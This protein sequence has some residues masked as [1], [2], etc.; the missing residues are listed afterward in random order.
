MDVI[1]QLTPREHVLQRPDTYVGSVQPEKQ[2][3]Y[4]Y[5]PVQAKM[6]AKEITVV[7]ALYKIVDEI[8]VNAAD[9]TQ[10]ETPTTRIDVSLDPQSG[11]ISVWNDGNVIPVRKHRSIDQW[12]PEL[13]FGSLLTSDNYDDSKLRTTGGRN[14]VGA[15]CTNIL[16]SCFRVEVV[17]LAANQKFSQVWTGNMAESPNG[18]QVTAPLK[19]DRQGVLV[20]FTP[21]YRYFNVDGLDADTLGLLRR[22][23]HDIAGTTGVTMKLDGRRFRFKAFGDYVKLFHPQA[24]IVLQSQQG[25]W[26]VVV[27][28]KP[29]N[30]I[31][32]ALQFVNNVHTSAGGTHV[33]SIQTLVT[34]AVADKLKKTAKT[35]AVPSRL[36]EDHY[37]VLVSCLVD[38]PTFGSQG[39]DTL[40]LPASQ[41]GSQWELD[42]KLLHR[43]QKSSL[44]ASVRATLEQKLEKTLS[45]INGKKSSRLVGVPK[46][47][48]ANRAGTR[49]SP[50]CTLILTEG[51]S[52]KALAVA[53]LSVIGRDLYGVFPLKGKLINASKK[54][55]DVVSNKEVQNLVKILGL[56]LGHEY[57]SPQELRYGHVM[58]MTD[59]DCDGSHIKG[60]VINLF[61]KLWPSLLKIPGFLQQFITPVVKARRRGAETVEFYST[62]EYSAWAAANPGYTAKYYKGLGTSTSAEARVYF[63][64]LA[65]QRLGFSVP[66][67]DDLAAL[68]MAFDEQVETRKRWIHRFLT[69]R[70]YNSTP[71]WGGDVSYREFV[72]R[73]LIHFA[74]ASVLRAIPHALDGLK[75]GQRKVLWTLF[76]LPKK[77]TKVSQLMGIVSEKAHYHHGEVSLGKTIC[78]LAQNIVGKNNLSYLVPSGMF[79]TRLEG[80]SDCADP[81]YIF[82]E[83]AAVT[84]DLFPQVDAP[85]LTQ[86]KED[87]YLCEFTYYLPVIPTVLLNGCSGIAVG[88]SCQVPAFHPLHLA[89]AMEALLDQGRD[90]EFCLEPFFEGFVGQVGTSDK[91][92]LY[93]QGVLTKTSANCLTI[94]ELPVG[95]WTMDYVSFLQKLV[96]TNK[97]KKF[98]QHH[99]ETTIRFQ[100]TV[101]DSVYAQD[102]EELLDLFRLRKNYPVNLVLF[103]PEG[104]LKKYESVREIAQEFFAFRLQKYEERR[105]LLIASNRQRL[106]GLQNRVRFIEAVLTGAV[107]FHQQELDTVRADLTAQGFTDL[108]D[109]L[110]TSVSLLSKTRLDELKRRV[111]NVLAEIRVYSECDAPSLWRKDLVKLRAHLGTRGTDRKRKAVGSP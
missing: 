101:E 26:Q 86:A 59:Q 49:R 77:E 85:L 83:L 29:P 91:G 73:E 25:R 4:V 97:V 61:A 37:S 99:S 51:D 3:T 18:P 68:A 60:L 1:S 63:G 8:L 32:P 23:V 24:S 89:E 52:A 98:T 46:L 66:A 107:R 20:E 43:L 103:S 50:E 5:D 87:G 111:Q 13:A 80:G 78:R 108:D 42:D 31:W 94:S 76:Q 100:L 70:D 22:R 27:V 64:N 40:T 81:R 39:K 96:Q 45:K 38:N 105:L 82:T 62:A 109:L 67:P 53:G 93:T 54:K 69:D 17:D 10:R 104:T 102:L 33:R 21:D 58:I 47:E 11:R 16:S 79:G 36:I 75:P 88:Y 65:R 15:T 48:D 90:A 34:R 56:Q 41:F 44:L 92:K 6:E 72:D 9:N 7:P 106:A 12:L 55:Q 35:G 28:Q 14:G 84:E 2:F 30:E 74:W 110:G 95:Q 19:K 57:S 71:V